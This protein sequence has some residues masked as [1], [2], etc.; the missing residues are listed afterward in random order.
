VTTSI[1]PAHVEAH[2]W[3]VSL[4][5]HV[6]SG[7]LDDA[8]V[9]RRDASEK[10][11]TMG[12]PSRR[13]DGDL[14]FEDLTAE[15]GSRYTYRLRW[16]NGTTIR[17]SNEVSVLVPPLRFAILAV[18]P[19][20]SSG[21]VTVAFSLPDGAPTRIEMFDVSSRRVWQRDVGSFGAGD[22]TISFGQE[23]VPKAGVYLIRLVRAGESRV[24]RIS[25]LR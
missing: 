8:L 11:L 24:R 9:E 5:W 19:N 6:E 21:Q 4:S 2:P 3:H 14:A 17:V 25:L 12:S 7:N 23:G 20:P 15:P 13:S 16:V 22:H 1:G 18:S 10:W